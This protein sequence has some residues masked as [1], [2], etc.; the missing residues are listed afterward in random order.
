M[1][2]VVLSKHG[3]HANCAPFMSNDHSPPALCALMRTRTRKLG[4]IYAEI[5]LLESGFAPK[6]RDYMAGIA[7]LASSGLRQAK[8]F[9]YRRTE[10]ERAPV[11]TQSGFAAEMNAHGVV[12]ESPVML[13]LYAQV[14]RAGANDRYV[15]ILGE[16][17]TGKELVARAI[18]RHRIRKI[19]RAH[20]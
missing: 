11:F 14:K 3:R 16:P 5:P 13:R 4:V 7:G 10:G 19:G 12:G 18:H 17:G 15:L 8:S 2:Q 20:V 9:E 6:H 1:G